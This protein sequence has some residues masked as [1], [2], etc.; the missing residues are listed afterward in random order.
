M[1]PPPG[2]QRIPC[3]LL[4]LC[5]LPLHCLL[6]ENT[7][8]GCG[9]MVTTKG[10]GTL[11]SK[12]YPGT[13]PNGTFCERH[14]QVPEG[15]RLHIKFGDLD[16][17]SHDCDSSYLKILKGSSEL[18]IV[19][20]CG[21]MTNAPS[22]IYLDSNEA[23]I[24]FK[25]GSHVSGRGFLL[26]FATSDHPDLI[27]CLERSNRFAESEFSRYCPAGCRAIAGAVSGDFVEGYRDTS[28]LCKAAIHAGVIADELGGQIGVIQH[29]GIGRYEGVLANGVLSVDGSLSDRRFVF[30]PNGCSTPLLTE[31]AANSSS[32]ITATSSWEST[33][34]NGEAVSWTP[35]GALL[36]G[37]GAPWASGRNTLGE[38]LEIDLG[39]RK[40]ITGIVTRG[41]T[42]PDFIFYVQ[43][44][45][46]QFSR[47]GMKW[48][49]YKESTNGEEKVFT[50]NDNFFD[51]ARNSFLR[52]IVARYVRVVPHS[53]NQRIALKVELLGCRQIQGNTSSAQPILQKPT[54]SSSTTLV[55]KDWTRTDHNPLEEGHTVFLHAGTATS[56]RPLFL[57]SMQQSPDAS[58]VNK[59]W[60][61]TGAIPPEER[62]FGNATSGRPMF[63][64]PNQ[65]SGVP[66]EKG[67]QAI[68]EPIPSEEIDLGM[69]LAAIVAPAVLALL[70]LIGGICLYAAIRKKKM[71]GSTRGPGN[72]K[73]AGC[74]KQI[75][76]PF[77]RQQSTEFTIS[78]NNEKETIQKLD[79]V[80]SDMADFQLPLLMVGT[81]TVTKKG[82]TFKP[83]DTEMKDQI[84]R[85][86][87][88]NHYDY[89][90]R[91]S[92]H[93]YALPLMNKEPEYATPII[94]RHAK[95]DNAL[96]SA[97]GY[98]VPVLAASPLLNYPVV[99]MSSLKDPVGGD[100]KSPQSMRNS[101]GD[102]DQPK[103][104][105]HMAAVGGCTDYQKP[106]LCFVV[107][108]GYS[109]PRDCLNPI[110]HSS[111]ISV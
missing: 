69:K 109:A 52:P 73:K 48:R 92:R 51:E 36:Q 14:I 83:L 111:V 72:I 85:A 70:L 54:H 96:T 1:L 15:K 45:G 40:R 2:A 98:N 71:N 58:L 10:S 107:D 21:T 66:A 81:D 60:T 87:I 65:T 47:D 88:E 19:T 75:K 24:R 64:K 68:T 31:L 34:S 77:A 104:N 59:D 78:Y 32:R 100:Y 106:Q 27:T 76:Q 102:Y 18:E 5:V 80:T 43:T 37:Q 30:T 6:A 29:K 94:E 103:I 28:L 7:A 4:A 67:D 63:Y 97:P 44:Y 57:T 53:W 26:N 90:H 17:E 61:I 41:S 55:K 101:E 99:G 3:L 89:P 50:G 95:R 22:E 20:Y 12:N 46:I 93:E 105:K 110:I 82:S 38:W 91:A 79:L 23:T 86:E 56:A 11:A 25:S 16:I 108:D 84:G 39:E 13:Y 35:E 33:N 8:D 74:W 9:H 42:K 49:T 62:D